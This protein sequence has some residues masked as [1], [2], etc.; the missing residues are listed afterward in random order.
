MEC[1]TKGKWMGLTGNTRSPFWAGYRL[2]PSAQSLHVARYLHSSRRNILNT[3]Q[4]TSREAGTPC[5][6]FADTGA[7][8][9]VLNTRV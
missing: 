9:G 8:L 7:R 4:T 5:T 6:H 1:K 3:E 2:I